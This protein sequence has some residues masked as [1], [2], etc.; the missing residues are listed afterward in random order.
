MDSDETSSICTQRW[1]LPGETLQRHKPLNV[2]TINQW[3]MISNLITI[4]FGVYNGGL[5][6]QNNQKCLG[7]YFEDAI[8]FC[9][10]TL[11][12]S[13]VHYYGSSLA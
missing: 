8:T 2:L 6:F 3:C 7:S 4:H 11:H 1:M 10:L 13:N 5:L 12:Y 9:P